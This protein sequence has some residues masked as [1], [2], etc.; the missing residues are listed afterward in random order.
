MHVLTPQW[1][2][3]AALLMTLTAAIFDCAKGVI[4]RWVSLGLLP[5]G[6]VVHAV[7]MYGKRAPWGMPGAL[8]GALLS[9]AG[10]ALC[11]LV[12]Y[13][14]FR[15]R[16]VGGGDVKVLASLGAL[17]GPSAGISAEFYALLL[18]ALYVPMRLAYQ[19]RLLSTIYAS[20]MAAAN[21][22]LS[23]ARRRALP[24]AMFE[25]IRLG[26]FVFAGTFFALASSSL[27]VRFA[28]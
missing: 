9:V 24:D 1:L 10:M 16:I 3:V 22:L 5:V 21:P 8:F 23:A 25:G 20:T 27:A 17:L 19:G 14:A 26:P 28:P 7:L 4:P 12:P 18:A 15:F 2:V 6:P 13:L 11:A